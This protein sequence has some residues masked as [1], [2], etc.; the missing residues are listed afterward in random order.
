[1]F[2][3]P[4]L[5]GLGPFY[6]LKRLSPVGEMMKF[7]VS[8]FWFLWNIKHHHNHAPFMN[9]KV[10]TQNFIIELT[11]VISTLVLLRLDFVIFQIFPNLS[12]GGNSE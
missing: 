7:W 3:N 5:H 9:Q 12:G 11:G 6:M 10:V 8:T 4:S 2:S 1:M